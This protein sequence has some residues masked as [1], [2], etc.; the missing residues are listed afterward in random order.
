MV[1]RFE[2]GYGLAPTAGNGARQP[3]KSACVRGYAGSYNAHDFT[4][5]Y[6]IQRSKITRYV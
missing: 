6:A 5:M 4:T 2:L 1:A 3:V